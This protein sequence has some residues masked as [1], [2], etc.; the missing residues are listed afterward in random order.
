[1]QFRETVAGPE[2]SSAFASVY[3][4]V[5]VMPL[6]HSSTLHV[7]I[8]PA[9]DPNV[10]KANGT[11]WVSKNRDWVILIHGHGRYGDDRKWVSGWKTRS[12]NIFVQGPWN[13]NS[14]FLFTSQGSA[15]AWLSDASFWGTKSC[16]FET[17]Y[18]VIPEHVALIIPTCIWCWC[19][20]HF[21]SKVRPDSSFT[22]RERHS[23]TFQLH[24]EYW[25]LQVHIS[26]V[27]V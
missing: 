1:M 5:N 8:I 26:F 24:T 13:P 2:C 15:Q 6:R 9:G 12:V 25:I 22:R 18:E 14:S 7:I 4:D 16:I 11:P 20:N 27:H 23:W 19:H 17:T 3:I 21:V 10:W